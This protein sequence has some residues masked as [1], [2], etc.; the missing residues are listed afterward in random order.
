MNNKSWIIVESLN[1]WKEDKKNNFKLIGINPKKIKQKK[2]SNGDIFFTYISKIKKFSDC[3]R[4]ISVETH[5]TPSNI[6]YDKDFPNCI[7]TEIVKELK[8]E[9]W[10]ELKLLLNSLEIF[11]LTKSPQLKLLNAPTLINVYDSNQLLKLMKI[12]SLNT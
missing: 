12:D 9:N 3:R 11:A 7:K 6:N 2:I 10:L 5:E 4:V 8:E 1:N